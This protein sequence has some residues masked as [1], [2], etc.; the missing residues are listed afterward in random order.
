MERGARQQLSLE[1]LPRRKR[2]EKARRALRSFK[3]PP[4]DIRSYRISEW[5]QSSL[6]PK[7]VKGFE[8]WRQS[9]SALLLEEAH[10]DV[11]VITP[12]M[13]S[14]TSDEE[15]KDSLLEAR[16]L[17]LTTGDVVREITRQ[18][19][20]LKHQ[21]DDQLGL[22]KLFERHVITMVP[23][24]LNVSATHVNRL[25]TQEVKRHDKKLAPHL[26]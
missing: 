19:R 9:R 2:L 15:I 12:E 5:S 26:R 11:I 4:V 21:T 3:R 8:L 14:L 6:A 17:G 1:W 18:T 20:Q 22:T 25:Y 24:A 13:S 10:Q 7:Y 23:D 16:R